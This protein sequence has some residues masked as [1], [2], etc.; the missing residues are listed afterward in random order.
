MAT[1][2]L[3]LPAMA[4]TPDSSGNVYAEPYPIKATSDF[5]KHL[6][7]VFADSATKDSAYLA[8][9]VPQNYVG[10]AKFGLVWTAQV[11]TGNVLWEFAYRTVGGDDTTSLDQA[12]AEETLT[13]TDAAPTATDRRLLPTMVAATAGNFTAGETV[14]LK[15]SRDGSS[16]TDTMAGAASLFYIVFQYTDV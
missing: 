9:E 13:I 11:T 1:H 8:F 5:W 16:A 4:L 2:N 10:T 15:F 7:L 14:E 6:N 3:I 12:T